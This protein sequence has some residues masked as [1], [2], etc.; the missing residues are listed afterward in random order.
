MD[1]MAASV[2]TMPKPPEFGSA[3]MAAEVV[4]AYWMAEL[5]DEH[6]G[7]WSS[8]DLSDI[9]S[10]W[11]M[12]RN[13]H[14]IDPDWMDDTQPF[15]GTF[16]GSKQGPYLSQFLLHT[17]RMGN[18]PVD[19]VVH[20]LPNQ[21]FMTSHSDTYDVMS[22][23]VG[24][25]P[26]PFGKDLSQTSDTNVREYISTGRNLASLVRKE[27]SYQH[28]L[29]AALQMIEGGTVDEPTV[30]FEGDVS[31]GSP[32]LQYVTY[33]GAGIFDLL[34]RAAGNALK[35][36]WYQKWL[37]HRRAR[38]EGAAATI[39]N[40]QPS[41]SFHPGIVKSS[42]AYS[43]ANSSQTDP[44]LSQA[45]HEGSPT[46]PSYPSGHS[47][48]AGA[49]ATVL[50]AMFGAQHYSDMANQNL[51]VTTL[52]Q[53]SSSGEPVPYDPNDWENGPSDLYIPGE[54]NKLVDNIGIARMWAGV[55]YWSDHIYG[56]RLGEQIG[57]A[58]LIN[59]DQQFGGTGD[60]SNIV[61]D[62]LT[63]NLLITKITSNIYQ[64]LEDLRA[65]DAP[66]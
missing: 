20:P 2:A 10:D 42:T 25:N 15:R 35:A 52:M 66:S 53:S 47:A 19:P 56:A 3:E 63:G 43:R 8:S 6:V 62:G 50:K 17:S 7:H 22:G 49:C 46:H 29:L 26:E 59:A 39:D 41:T 9:Q 48:I 11:S 57:L 31:D 54:L 32:I 51:E 45:Y 65:G 44:V 13:N 28:Y 27:P 60:A 55:H 61:I 16:D 18:T 33:G 38:P 4:H 14:G 64:T 23:T 1:G 12:I 21:D 37:V 58:T 5:R 24:G 36:A 40:D 30:P 34:A